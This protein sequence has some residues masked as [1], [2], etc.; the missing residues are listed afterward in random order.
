MK[1]RMLLPIL[2]ILFLSGCF[3]QK[4][5]NS[6]QPVQASAVWP[7][8]ISKKMEDHLIVEADVQA[9]RRDT[10]QIFEGNRRYL[11]PDELI[12][13]FQVD[14]E[15]TRIVHNQEDIYEVITDKRSIVSAGRMY[16]SVKGYRSGYGASLQ[17]SKSYYTMEEEFEMGTAIMEESPQWEEYQNV[18]DDV[19][20]ITGRFGIELA[21]APRIL[22][23]LTGDENRAMLEA[24]FGIDGG[25]INPF[26]RL[27]TDWK[28]ED[29][30]IYVVWDICLDGIPMMS[31]NYSGEN[32]MGYNRQAPGGSLIACYHD[33][34][35]QG[36][37]ITAF[38]NI[39]TE[40]GN[41]GMLIPPEEAMEA[42]KYHFR[43]I[44]LE[45][46]I[47]FSNIQLSYVPCLTD[48]DNQTFQFVPA[49]LFFGKQEICGDD[50]AS[51]R[52]YLMKVNA[53]TGE[54]MH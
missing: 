35:L 9:V 50:W 49:W 10:Y 52:A 25:G 17:A 15:I 32:M 13:A 3:F 28:T 27:K 5:P 20:N 34:I 26:M 46:D 45:S 51:D 54:M 8:H 14:E 30:C 47:I 53:I 19:M 36:M 37:D 41:V 24:K 7:S 2:L 1:Y 11:S 38:Y 22:R 18:V 23:Y 6:D 44:I 43:N 21:K 4:Q 16:Y 39:G 42:I 40:V 31:G 48:Y 29:D 12:E 33:G